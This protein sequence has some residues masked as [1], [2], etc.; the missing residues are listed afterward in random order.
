MNHLWILL[1]ACSSSGTI[2]IGDTGDLKGSQSIPDPQE[3]AEPEPDYTRWSGER[4]IIYDDCEGRLEEEG[5]Q[6]DSSWEHY[7][8]VESWCL[9][10]KGFYRVDVGPASVCGLDVSQEVYRAIWYEADEAHVYNLDLSG[11]RWELEP[12]DERG[13]FDG[14]DIQYDYTIAVWGEDIEVE[15]LVSFPML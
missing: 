15:G 14:W 12:L 10:C 1:A 4:T 8:L 2:E 11:D 13:S 9:E 6:L 7:D 3:E 5:E